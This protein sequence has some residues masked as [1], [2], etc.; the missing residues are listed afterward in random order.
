MRAAMWV[1][2][3]MVA[4]GAF[5]TTAGYLGLAT[6]WIVLGVALMAVAVATRLVVDR[7]PA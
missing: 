7:R 5:V 3:T 1:G 6:E 4:G 2:A